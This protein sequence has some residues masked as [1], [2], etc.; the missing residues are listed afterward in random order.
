M[1]WS[2]SSL[3]L[4]ADRLHRIYSLSGFYKGFPVQGILP[5]GFDDATDVSPEVELVPELRVPTGHLDI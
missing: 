3:V 1:N 5:H 4:S 2:K